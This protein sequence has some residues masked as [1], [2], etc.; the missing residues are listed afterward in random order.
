MDRIEKRLLQ[1]L[2]QIIE[3]GKQ[4][5]V[6]HVNSVLTV[7]YWHIGK[8]INEHILGNERAEYG[9]K[10]IVNVTRQLKKQFGRSYTLR[11]VRRMIQF[12]QEFPDLQIVSPLATQL[13]W[14]HFIELLPLI[15]TEKKMYYAQ[16]AAE[17]NWSRNVL[18]HQIERKIYERNEIAKPQTQELFS[19]PP[20]F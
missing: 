14:S 11:N 2:T 1:D 12:A 10:V 13:S 17:E 4:Q 8:R 6:A 19:H 5:A 16:K 3:Q 7:T 9:E 15:T 18:R 20:F